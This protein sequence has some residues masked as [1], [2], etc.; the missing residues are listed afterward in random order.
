MRGL[1]YLG[2]K[3][4]TKG[5]VRSNSRAPKQRSQI[6]KQTMVA[7]NLPIT[8]DGLTGNGFGYVV[9][10]DFPQGNILFLGAA[11]YMQLSTVSG[12]VT[13]TFTGSYSVGTVPTTDLTLSGSEVDIVPQVILSAA[14]AQVSPLTRGVSPAAMSGTVFDNTDNSLSI[15]INCIIDNASINANGVACFLNGSIVLSYVVLTD[16]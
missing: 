11:S 2:D 14:T 15:N 8:I 16:D 12:S 7:K 5:L 10:S 1:I 9:I 4:M 6:I 13:A 3:G